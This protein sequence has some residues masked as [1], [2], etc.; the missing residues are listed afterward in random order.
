MFFASLRRSGPAHSVPAANLGIK[1]LGPSERLISQMQGNIFTS[2]RRAQSLF[3]GLSGAL[4]AKISCLDPSLCGISGLALGYLLSGHIQRA[5]SMRFLEPFTFSAHIRAHYFYQTFSKLYELDQEEAIQQAAKIAF[6]E[7]VSRTALACLERSFGYSRIVHFSLTQGQTTPFSLELI[8]NM[9]LF[10][11]SF[12]LLD[13]TFKNNPCV[14]NGLWNRSLHISPAQHSFLRAAVANENTKW[15]IRIINHG[16]P[17]FNALDFSDLPQNKFKA[18]ASVVLQTDKKWESLLQTDWKIVSGKKCAVILLADSSADMLS[19][20]KGK[21]SSYF[22]RQIM[23]PL[24]SSGIVPL[25]T[26]VKTAEEIYEKLDDLKSRENTVEWLL[27]GGHGSSS[28]ISL[29]ESF[30]FTNSLLRKDAFQ[31][32]KRMAPQGVVVLY[33]CSTGRK[34]GDGSCFAKDLADQGQGLTVFS[35]SDS[36]NG[37][38]FHSLSPPDYKFYKY[39]K[40]CT[41]IYRSNT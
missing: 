11:P 34:N 28:G 3:L 32:A 20:L 27:I 10:R 15:C 41:A 18:I 4:I 9:P 12:K 6:P 40:E 29:S 19:F 2:N 26:H 25:A 23:K 21:V 1:H 17:L 22:I 35:A 33:S 8:R 14:L 38:S 5:K 24:Q 30:I 7:D 13:F 39:D 16:L 31:I 37:M 36:M